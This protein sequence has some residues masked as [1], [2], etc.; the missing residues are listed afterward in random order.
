MAIDRVCLF[1]KSFKCWNVFVKLLFGKLDMN[2]FSTQT[3]NDFGVLCAI[4]AVRM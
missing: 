2:R 1:L 3:R 4:A